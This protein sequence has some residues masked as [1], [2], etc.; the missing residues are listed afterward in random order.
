MVT[1]YNPSQSA[2]LSFSVAEADV[3]LPTRVNATLAK[4]VVIPGTSEDTQV[5]EGSVEYQQNG[6]WYVLAPCTVVISV[7]KPGT[8]TFVTIGTFPIL[9]MGLFH[10]MFPWKPT[11]IG[12]HVVRVSYNGTAPTGQYYGAEPSY[13]E[14]YAIVN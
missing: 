1:Y 4:A 10:Y 14:L 11:E 2:D 7:K 3:Y 8:S 12:T 5:V 13:T 9:G 6:T